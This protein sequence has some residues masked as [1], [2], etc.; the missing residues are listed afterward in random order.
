MAGE[1]KGGLLF[2]NQ[3]LMAGE[4][5]ARLISAN[6][7]DDGS[8]FRMDLAR[9]V[10]KL[11][12]IDVLTGNK[13]Q[14]LYA[15]AGKDFVG[16]LFSFLTLLLGTISRLVAK[17]SDI[18]AVKFGSLS[19]L[20]HS[21]SDLDELYLCILCARTRNCEGDICGSRI[22]S[23]R[24]Q[25]FIC[26]KDMTCVGDGFVKETATFIIRDDLCVMPNDLGASL[27][28][29]QTHGVLQMLEGIYILLLQC[30][31]DSNASM[32]NHGKP[33]ISHF[34]KRSATKILFSILFLVSFQL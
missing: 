31:N 29:L 24:N 32:Q 1:K 11:S 3:Q 15:E 23:V 22:S 28:L 13:G 20:H 26:G 2:A 30:Q 25:K 21:V 34:V 17:E 6:A 14:L 33:S 18:D 5:T 10:L 27:R 12:N 4:N 7:S 9:V 16:A 8:T 19:T